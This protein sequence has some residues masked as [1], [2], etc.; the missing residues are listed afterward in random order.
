MAAI[1]H[2][3]GLPPG[4]FLGADL[5]MFLRSAVLDAED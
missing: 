2:S 5:I 4:F 3:P 1:V